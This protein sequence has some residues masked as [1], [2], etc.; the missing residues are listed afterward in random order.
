MSSLIWFSS[1]SLGQYLTELRDRFQCQLDYIVPGDFSEQPSA[2]KD[3]RN[4]D[5]YPS[6]CFFIENT[7]YNDFRYESLKWSW[8]LDNGQYG[9]DSKRK[10]NYQVNL[11]LCRGAF[12]GVSICFFCLDRVSMR[13]SV[14][15]A[16]FGGQKGS[17]VAPLLL[18]FRLLSLFQHFC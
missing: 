2:D 6:G 3:R 8:M 11:R 12:S 15:T 14:E 18:W 1:L 16:I 5:L 13:P 9:S 7:F 4:R 17:L 10:K